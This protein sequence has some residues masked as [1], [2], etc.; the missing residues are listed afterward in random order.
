MDA[1]RVIVTLCGA[2][3]IVVVNVWFF[4]RRGRMG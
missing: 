1:A 2:G 3:L 4:G